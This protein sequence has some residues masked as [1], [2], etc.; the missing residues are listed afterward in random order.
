MKGIVYLIEWIFNVPGYIWEG[1]KSKRK[2]NYWFIVDSYKSVFEP[3]KTE[4]PFD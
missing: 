4:Y 3:I 2:L 1:Q